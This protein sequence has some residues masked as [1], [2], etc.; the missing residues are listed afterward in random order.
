[1][2]LFLFYFPFK[3]RFA[4]NTLSR[5]FQPWIPPENIVHAEKCGI[6]SM[7]GNIEK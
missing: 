6:V 2:E 1:M 5:Q 4:C 7:L 3:E